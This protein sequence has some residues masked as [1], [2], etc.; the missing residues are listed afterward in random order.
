MEFH[1]DGS[2]DCTDGSDE[3]DCRKCLI[4]EQLV[5]VL[6][7]PF[8]CNVFFFFVFFFRHDQS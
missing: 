3:E 4:I 2:N 1:C 5:S 8:I 6:I 7:P